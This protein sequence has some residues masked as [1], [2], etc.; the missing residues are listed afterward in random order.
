MTELSDTARAYHN[1]GV[2]VIP[3]QIIRNDNGIFDKK[4][5]L[6]R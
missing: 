5:V 4:P 6:E 3:F 1:L 2:P